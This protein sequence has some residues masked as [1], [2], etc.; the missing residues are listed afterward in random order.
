MKLTPF[1]CGDEIWEDPKEAVEKFLRSEGERDENYIK[2]GEKLMGKEKFRRFLHEF[3]LEFTKKKLREA[4]TPDSLISHLVSSIEEIDKMLNTL[5][6]RLR[7]VYGLMRPRDVRSVESM[8]KLL[9]M[10]KRAKGP[11]DLGSRVDPR[12]INYYVGLMEELMR[13][14]TKIVKE[15]DELMEER[16]PNLKTLAGALLGAKLISLSGSLENLAKLP[17]STIQLLGAERALFRH[18]TRGAK[19][20]KHGI[21]IQHPLVARA[22]KKGK[23]ARSLAAKIAIAAKVDYFG[24]EFVG[25]KL[26]E[27]LE[28]KEYV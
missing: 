18:L 14:R 9:K 4:Y 16:A 2:V 3:F 11:D 1:G 5:Y 24:G 15:I 8:E 20:P 6:E 21:L 19:P 17:S 28:E 27:E 25:D 23:A 7:E 13:V 26:L 12:V 10:A 22:K